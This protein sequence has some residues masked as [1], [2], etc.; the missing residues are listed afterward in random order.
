MDNRLKLP[1]ERD[2]VFI[3]IEATDDK[4]YQEMI[5]F[6][7]IRQNLDGEEKEFDQLLIPKKQLSNYIIN[8][9]KIDNKF[10][11]HHGKS[12][13]ECKNEISDFVKDSVIISFG[14]WDFKFLSDQLKINLVNDLNCEQYDLQKELRIISGK[15]QL[16][17]L[18]IYNFLFEQNDAFKKYQH[19]ATFDTKILK[20]I[21]CKIKNMSIEELEGLVPFVHLMPRTTTACHKIFSKHDHLNKWSNGS[22]KSKIPF[23]IKK[24]E[25]G[26]FE[27][28]ENNKQVIHYLKKL[29][30]GFKAPYNDFVI[31]LE[32][33]DIKSSSIYD[34]YRDEVQK[35]LE[36]F[37]DLVHNY[38]IIFY[39]T[40]KDKVQHFCEL[41]Y[42]A[43]KTYCEINYIN[44]DILKNNKNQIDQYKEFCNLIKQLP[45][46]K[47]NKFNGYYYEKNSY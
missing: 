32:H 11:M 10:L 39:S 30:G 33:Y 38:K 13:E 47:K 36:K 27:N 12:L 7:A 1:N 9:L 15:K 41:I 31:N 40:S 4:Y 2:L 37:L 21:F 29:I 22:L 19:C 46:D 43:T 20:D 24:I 34:I 3:D 16:P 17:L 14:D 28:K 26:K 8:L 45:K 25:I 35:K 44:L 23:I 5:Q 42:D 18:Q 6:S